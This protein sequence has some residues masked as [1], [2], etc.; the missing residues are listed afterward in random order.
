M[1]RQ[2]WGE[3]EMGLTSGRRYFLVFVRL[4]GVRRRLKIRLTNFF[5]SLVV[6]FSSA[7]VHGAAQVKVST[8]GSIM[9]EPNNYQRNIS[10]V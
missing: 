10:V 3:V 5:E 6:T 9:A 7:A 1:K 2:K 8:V 4:K